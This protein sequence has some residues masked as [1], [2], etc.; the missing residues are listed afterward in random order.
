M[1]RR[2]QVFV[3]S[4][5]LD[6]REARAEVMQALL[7]LDCIPAGM[8]LFPASN[9]TQWTLIKRVI[10]D[11]DYY[12][13]IIGGRYGSVD[14]AGVSYTEREYDYAVERGLPALGFVHAEPEAIPL[15]K[16]ETDPAARA[17][18]MDFRAKVQKR[19]CKVWRSPEELGGVVS[20]S[21]VQTMKISPAE[22]WVRARH[23]ASPEQINA[24]R[25]QIDELTKQLQSVRTEA[26]SEAEG[27]A[28]GDDPFAIG[29]LVE[30]FDLSHSGTLTLTWDE[31]MAIVGPAMYDE[32]PEKE[33][34]RLLAARI[35]GEVNEEF[36]I[37]R[38]TEVDFQTIKVQL[39]ALGLIQKSVR[40]RAIKDTET[41]WSLTPYGERY[42]TLLKA[43]RV[44]P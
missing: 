10:E 16:S 12:L 44:S 37:L 1:D 4:T 28:K 24:L 20:R 29:Y 2:F 21:L 18:L 31:I 32:A 41:Y 22:G 6:L 15:G 43:I 11:C 38:V 40:K 14:E 5:F 30:Q 33:L 8:E 17:K 36:D 19:M 26:P 3:S 34:R 9:E 27:L 7:E 25:S 35:A 39:L 13:V 42:T 23:A